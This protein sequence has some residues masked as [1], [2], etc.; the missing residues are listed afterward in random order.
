MIVVAEMDGQPGEIWEHIDG[1]RRAVGPR[2]SGYRN[3]FERWAD[4]CSSL[5][6]ASCAHSGRRKRTSQS[7]TSGQTAL[8]RLHKKR[9]GGAMDS[10]RDDEATIALRMTRA[11]RE[12]LFGKRNSC[13]GG[14]M[15]ARQRVLLVER[16]N[17]TTLI[18]TNELRRF[19]GLPCGGFEDAVL[20]EGRKKRA[21]GAGRRATPI[22]ACSGSS[23]TP[24]L[25]RFFRNAHL[26]SSGCATYS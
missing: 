10:L 11:S 8:P 20:D 7:R 13:Q 15:V 23:G 16:Q 26:C 21:L 2:R 19:V 22:F 14:I 6:D 5:T 3:L 9:G 1:L 17:A 4:T 24:S 25:A 18:S 12:G